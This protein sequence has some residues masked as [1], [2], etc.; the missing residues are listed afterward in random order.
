MSV[1]ISNKLNKLERDLPEGLLVTASWLEQKGYYCSLRNKYVSAGWLEQTARGVFRR[2]RGKISWEQ[3]VISLQTLLEYGVSVGGRTALELQG[4]AHYLP[5]AQ[6]IIHLYSDQKLPTWLPKL[7]MDASFEMHNRSRFLPILEK[8]LPIRSLDEPVIADNTILEGALRVTPWGQWKWP[9]IISTPE[10]A[11][12][13][14]LAAVPE[15]ETF[16][17]A[18]VMMEGLGNLSPRRMQALLESAQNIKVK[19]L[20]FF[21]ADRHNHSWLRHISRDKIDLGH[22][23]RMLVKGG[24][25]DTKY[26]ITVPEDYA[27]ENTHGL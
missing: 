25:F 5:Q 20:F 22:G 13:E 3:V 7:S 19:R 1:R 2:P 27:M 16:H 8:Q 24:K 6:K 15:Y 23:K 17:M 9:L 10:R 11:Y 26:Q 18:D 4:Y 21:F 14:L 12:L